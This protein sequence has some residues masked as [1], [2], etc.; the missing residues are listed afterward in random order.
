MSGSVSENVRED[1]S[2]DDVHLECSL[3]IVSDGTAAGTQILV[4]GKRV[5]LVQSVRIQITPEGVLLNLSAYASSMK[6]KGR[7]ISLE[8][9]DP[10]PKK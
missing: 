9:F 5:K 3:E 10:E 4:D 6:M 8:A 7:I 2:I 1:A